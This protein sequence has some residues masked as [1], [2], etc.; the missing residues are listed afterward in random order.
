R[1]GPACAPGS[2]AAGRS[3]RAARRP[4]A[5][6]AAGGDARFGARAG[7]GARWERRELL[8][9]PVA[10]GPL[11]A[12]VAAPAAD[13]DRRRDGHDQEQYE[14][15]HDEQKPVH[16]PGGRPPDRVRAVV[17]RG[18][19]AARSPGAGEAR[20]RQEGVDGAA[21]VDALQLDRED[22]LAG[23]DVLARLE[24]E[25]G[26]DVVARRVLRSPAEV[27]SP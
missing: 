2:R 13:D 25:V 20:A 6:I 21:S 14:G 4:R 12:A 9:E 16:L 17:G 18:L 23:A 5:A 8:A 15:G 7:S 24:E 10:E 11:G 26:D 19:H 22:H 27:A 1:Y 3:R